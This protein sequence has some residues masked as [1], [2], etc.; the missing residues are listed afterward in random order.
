MLCVLKKNVSMK[1]FFWAHKTYV[2]T[3]ELE[4]I[5]NFMLK[6]FVYLNLCVY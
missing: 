1:R 4:S 6:D 5:Y 2:Q 3:D